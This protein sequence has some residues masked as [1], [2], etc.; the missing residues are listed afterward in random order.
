LQTSTKALLAL[1]VVGGLAFAAGVVKQRS[2]QAPARPFDPDHFKVSTIETLP[3][4]PSPTPRIQ[5]RF[6]ALPATDEP[7]GPWGGPFRLERKVAT[8]WVPLAPGFAG[9]LGASFDASADGKVLWL[10][11]EEG[12]A[13]ERWDLPAGTHTSV[14]VGPEPVIVAL[15][16]GEPERVA[17]S[18]GGEE[19]DRLFLL[20]D[21]TP[22][23]VYPPRGQELV[24]GLGVEWSEDGQTLLIR[25]EEHRPQE[26]PT[27]K[28]VWLRPDGQVGLQAAVA[29]PLLQVETAW[30]AG[31]GLAVGDDGWLWRAGEPKAR[32]L[33]TL[34]R[35]WGLDASGALAAGL[36]EDK[37][38]VVELAEPQK[39]R[40]LKLTGVPAEFVPEPGGLTWGREGIAVVGDKRGLPVVL[41]LRLG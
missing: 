3:W 2:H 31:G 24:P 38:V 13:L 28:L 37:L 23:Q 12:G 36:L 34:G 17:F 29:A 27:T 35:S 26:A 20:E 39:R 11:R 40:E 1:C 19:G 5:E 33:G 7:G 9:V 10:A 25:W 16:P 15:A 4:S 32:A 14:A 8:K 18:L 30:V 21:N 6:R 41:K 22:R